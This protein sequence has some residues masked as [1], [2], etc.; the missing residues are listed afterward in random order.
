MISIF[1]LIYDPRYQRMNNIKRWQFERTNGE[2]SL[3]SHSFWVCLYT[4]FLLE[5]LLAGEENTAEFKLACSDYALLHDFRE[6]FTGDICHEVKVSIPDIKKL[7][8]E[9]E[10]S[11]FDKNYSGESGDIFVSFLDKN[12]NS[13]NNVVYS[14]VK[15]ADWMN[16]YCFTHREV[17]CGNNT[18]IKLMD[19]CRHSLKRQVLSTIEVLKNETKEYKF[20]FNLEILNIHLNE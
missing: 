5:N 18:F 1:D 15:T 9:A 8:E 4:R 6:I 19:Y 17:I 7:L 3:S 13:K 11:L 2:E 12:S 10:I 16:M 14:I 20:S